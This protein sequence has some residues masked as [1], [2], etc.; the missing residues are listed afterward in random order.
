MKFALRLVLVASTAM[1]ARGG[2]ALSQEKPPSQNPAATGTAKPKVTSKQSMTVTATLTPEEVEEGK[3]N[4]VYDEAEALKRGGNCK[5]AV[6]KYEREV[7][8]RAQQS[9]F[10]V[11]RNKFLFL[12]TRDIAECLVKLDR[13]S[14]A[15]QKYVK[16][17]DYLAVWPGKEDSAYPET[18]EMIGGTQGRQQH[19]KEAEDSLRRSIQI[20]D[21]LIAKAAKSDSEFWRT[22]HANNLRQSEDLAMANLAGVI[23]NEGRI[24]EGLA[25]LEKAYAQASEFHASTFTLRSIAQ[26]GEN[27]AKTMGDSDAEARWKKRMPASVLQ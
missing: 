6:E 22:E 8:P 23:L 5:T 4:D 27:I 13:P 1:M 16:S 7:I 12:A 15:E 19:F 9:K 2:I 17:L 24:E 21:E 20:F 3:I 18:Y 10:Y 26:F 14:E 25:L 11:P